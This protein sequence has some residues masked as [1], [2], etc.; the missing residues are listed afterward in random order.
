MT[1]SWFLR[2]CFKNCQILPGWIA[3]WTHSKIWTFK[4]SNP[5]RFKGLVVTT[6]GPS[7]SCIWVGKSAERAFQWQNRKSDKNVKSGFWKVKNAA[8]W[9]NIRGYSQTLNKSLIFWNVWNLQKTSFRPLLNW[10]QMDSLKN[11][12]K[13]AWFWVKAIQKVVQQKMKL[14]KNR[15]FHT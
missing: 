11:V 8:P 9:R 15:L 13:V 1:K 2:Q 7:W 3:I 12:T 14:F 4:K 5:N 6:N 10:N